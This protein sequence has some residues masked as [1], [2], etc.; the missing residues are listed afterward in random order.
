MAQQDNYIGVAFG[1][2]VTDLK[3]GLAET[4]KAISQAD[5]K[6]KSATSGMDDWKD[7]IEGLGAEL[8]YLSTKLD[9]QKKNVRGYEAEIKELTKTY[10]E[11]SIQVEEHRKKL[12]KEKKAVADSEK[13]IRQKTSRL[14]MLEGAY[15]DTIDDV[16][17]LQ[18]SLRQLDAIMR[19]QKKT[20]QQ[21]EAQLARAKDE[22]GET[23]DEVKELNT[24]LTRAKAVFNDT[25]TAHEKYA[26][27]LDKV[28]SETREVKSETKKMSSAL[29]DADSATEQLKGGFT[30]LKGAMASLVADGI[31]GIVSGVQNVIEESREFRMEMSYLQATA[32]KTGTSFD[33]VQ[34][35]VKEVYAVLG[36][37]DSAVE[38]MNNLM[39]AGFDGEALDK[40][41][42]QLIGA[43]IQWHDTLKFEGLA[44]GLQETLATGKAIGPF[45]ELLERGGMVAEDFDEG[46][47]KCTTE[48]EKQNYVLETLSKL[49]LSEIAEG[50]RE[51]NKELVEGAEAQFE[52][53]EAM[54]EVGKKAE[55]ILSTIKEGWTGVLTAFTDLMND[56]DFDGLTETIEGAFKWFAEEGVPVIKDV[57]DFIVEHKD[58]ILTAVSGIA[59]GFL[60]WKIA[61]GFI[62][63]IMGV[64][65]AVMGLYTV[66][67]AN[68]IGLIV[69][70][71]A[72]LVAAFV[73]LWNNC[74]G[75][76]EFWINL[77]EKIK[78]VAGEVWEAIT[79]FFSEAWETIKG[80]WDGAVEFFTG[81]WQGIK[82]AYS[83][84]KQWFTDLFKGAWEGI[85]G[86]W[87]KAVG[88][89]KGVWD[90]IKNTYK[91]VKDWFTNLFKGAWEGIK[92]IWSGAKG[93]F[94][95]IWNGIKEV[96]SVV[97]SWFSNRFKLAWEGVKVIWSKVTVFFQAV[98]DGIKKI[99]SVVKNILTGNFSDAWKGI[100]D[101]WSGVSGWFKGIIDKIV[102]FFKEL[103]EK[104]LQIGKDM[105]TGI[106]DGIKDTVGGIGDAIKNGIDTGV[107]KVKDWL[108]IHSPSRLM[109]DEIGLM[110]GAG[111][112]E[113]IDDSTGL[114]E[115]SAEGLEDAIPTDMDSDVA[116]NLEVEDDL[117]KLEGYGHLLGQ[118]FAEGLND[119]KGEVQTALDS[120][121]NNITEKLGTFSTT[122]SDT[123]KGSGQ[124]VV[125]RFSQE[126][127]GSITD[128][129]PVGAK[130]NETISGRIKEFTT[131]WIST[132]STTGKKMIPEFIAGIENNLKVLGNYGKELY[133]SI[134]LKMAEYGVGWALYANNIGEG[135]MDGLINGITSKF[136]ELDETISELN[137]KLNRINNLNIEIESAKT[138]L[139]S[140]KNQTV[141]NSTTINQTIN[142]P[143]ALT[144]KEIYRQT[145]NLLNATKG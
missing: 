61:T 60:G 41:T 143:K 106:I 33:H 75:F 39:T 14:N 94:S 87:D 50:Y 77:W 25:K 122:W 133:T 117:S 90:G 68:P 85:K 34:D 98:W 78:E 110:I 131:G 91:G 139:Q 67:A 13:A 49:G 66:M 114:I 140:P 21:Y 115:D 26:K 95:G 142:S 108:G 111:I 59:A 17:E 118:A 84:V 113:G 44:D 72:A 10:G 102:G 46:L 70:A 6:F 120:F 51:T 23:S 92:A 3:A 1:L 71:I 20:V 93:F 135:M 97:T 19:N 83:S 55:P 103:P 35:K 99:F 80:I 12:A 109:R 130:L 137:A 47:A 128:F 7:T 22:Y 81:L 43:S 96:F 145:K 76:R 48:A 101:I 100:K 119:G 64:K 4:S 54:A 36:E 38:G 56:A 116:L 79:K 52:Y 88:F 107:D 24:R 15:V 57:I 31:K 27:Q 121:R 144:R 29:K 8:E 74:E 123:V 134:K 28:E 62:P 69:A 73:Y 11:N 9:N 129:T 82:D 138:K 86:I 32:D 89:F 2:D 18:G 132:I 45:V 141:N 40:I 63:A 127:D 37:Q 104:M 30:V 124:G 105:M 112:A 53:D 5:T 42:D 65:T 58:V 125:V 16:D 136:D 126:L